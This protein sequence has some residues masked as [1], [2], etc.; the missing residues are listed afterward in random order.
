VT[1]AKFSTDM[2]AEGEVLVKTAGGWVCGTLA[3]PLFHPGDFINCYRGPPETQGVAVCTSGV[4]YSNSSGTGFG[5]CVGEV[6]PQVETCDGVDNDCNGII[7]D[8]IFD[9]G[10]SYFFTVL[11]VLCLSIITISCAA[12]LKPGLMVPLE[13]I[14]IREE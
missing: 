11:A 6:V 8:N 1:L 2:C 5:E 9:A 13:M 4:R 3:A 14:L 7:D 12:F 10:R